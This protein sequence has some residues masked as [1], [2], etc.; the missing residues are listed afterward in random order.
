MART[1]AP[2]VVIAAS[3]VATAAMAQ[4]N[5]SQARQPV[6]KAAPPATDQLPDM[7]VTKQTVT[8]WRAPKLVGISVYGPDDKQV[9]TIKD[10]LI[11]HD[12]SAGAIVVGVGGF[13]GIGT[14]DVAVP[15]SAMQWRMESRKVP[16]TDQPPGTLTPIT[17]ATEQQPPMKETDPVA[18]EASQGYPDRAVL[19][20]PVAQLKTAPD[21]EYANS[22]AQAAPSSSSRPASQ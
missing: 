20:L 6:H 15:F 7:F 10:I 5:A 22:P 1:T 21:F 18:T 8:K 13:L 17:G 12:G 2:V 9:G 3:L 19:N 16:A 4:T 11:E 14:K